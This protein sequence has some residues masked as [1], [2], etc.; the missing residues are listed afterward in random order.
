MCASAISCCQTLGPTQAK[1]ASLKNKC[2]LYKVNLPCA[3]KFRESLQ[4]FI[5]HLQTSPSMLMSKSQTC[6]QELNPLAGSLQ[7]NRGSEREDDNLF[8]CC[9]KLLCK[10]HMSRMFEVLHPCFWRLKSCDETV[11]VAF[12]LTLFAHVCTPAV[13]I[14]NCAVKS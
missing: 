9:T 7:R 10:G 2:S 6:S 4:N 5:S 14:K 13:Q 1:E 3:C 8:Y 11:R 12:V